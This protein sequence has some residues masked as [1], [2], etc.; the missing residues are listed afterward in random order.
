MKSDIE[1]YE[2]AEKLT[3]AIN[4]IIPELERLRDKSLLTIEFDKYERNI[5]AIYTKIDEVKGIGATATSKIL[6]LLNPDLFV[7]WDQNI[8][9][10][11][12][13]CL[14]E[15]NFKEFKENIGRITET[16]TSYVRF[17]Q[18]MQKVGNE[19]LEEYMKERGIQD[20]NKAEE[21]LSKEYCGKSIV[22]LLDEY[23]WLIATGRVRN[24]NGTY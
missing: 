10:E 14:D 6:H 23:N 18:L 5:K 15:K 13:R 20:R 12:N 4:D 19:F 24:L 1:N 8:R 11:W 21:M 16:A 9:S 17:M 22:K 7:M 2:V 3:N